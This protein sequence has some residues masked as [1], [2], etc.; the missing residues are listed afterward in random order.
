MESTVAT[1]TGGDGGIGGGGGSA[2]CSD[3]CQSGFVVGGKG[4]NGLI[5]VMYTSVG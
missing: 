4:G 2:N 5:L 1:I 3:V